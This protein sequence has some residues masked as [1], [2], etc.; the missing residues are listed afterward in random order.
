MSITNMMEKVRPL[1]GENLEEFT[2]RM[3]PKIPE[4]QI[5]INND[6]LYEH[7]LVLQN[8]SLSLKKIL[9]E[10]EKEEDCDKLF[11]EYVLHVQNQYSEACSECEPL[12]CL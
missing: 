10:E 12:F 3:K 1:I 7:P 11:F 8:I 2:L 6:I 5:Q 4:I 9:A